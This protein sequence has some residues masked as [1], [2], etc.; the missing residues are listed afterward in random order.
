MGEGGRFTETV[1]FPQPSGNK[2]KIKK[3]KRK[4][5]RSNSSK[6]VSKGKCTWIRLVNHWLRD[7]AQLE[8]CL[9]P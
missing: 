1:A 6:N 8:K 2:Y 9:P 3:L 5:S 4:E 7:V